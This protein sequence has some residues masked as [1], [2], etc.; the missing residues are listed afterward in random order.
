MF[1]ATFVFGSKWK[2]SKLLRGKPKQRPT[3][4]KVMFINKAR[5]SAI[6]VP[7]LMKGNTSSSKCD[8]V[9]KTHL[10]KNDNKNSNIIIIIIVII[11]Y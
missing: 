5:L 4:K 10:F 9:E 6:L 3:P 1:I 7:I 11:K 8:F 2:D